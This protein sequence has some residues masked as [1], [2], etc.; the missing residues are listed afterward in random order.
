MAINDRFEK[1]WKF[2]LDNGNKVRND[3]WVKELARYFFQQG[4]VHH[5]IS[6]IE[7]EEIK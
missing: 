1:Q 7:E 5:K 4:W 6:Q 2:F 3:A